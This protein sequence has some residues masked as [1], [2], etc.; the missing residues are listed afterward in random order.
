MMN[1][2][3][4]PTEEIAR[5]RALCAAATPGPWKVCGADG[6]PRQDVWSVPVDAE[7]AAASAENECGEGLNRDAQR[8]NSVF[9]AT[10]RAAVPALLDALEAE[11]KRCEAAGDALMQAGDFA[12]EIVRS[13]SPSDPEL[14]AKAD[15]MEAMLKAI[16]EGRAVQRWQP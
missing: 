14:A 4:M 11:R 10:A 3:L 6:C 5:L 7:V 15:A 16:R 12:I 2:D 9:I 13:A 1:D 8:A